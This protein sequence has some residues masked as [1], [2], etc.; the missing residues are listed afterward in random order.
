MYFH[1]IWYRIFPFDIVVRHHTCNFLQITTFNSVNAFTWTINDNRIWWP[2]KCSQMPRLIIPNMVR[3]FLSCGDLLG[4]AHIIY[5]PEFELD[6]WWWMELRMPSGIENETTQIFGTL[7]GASI[8]T[9]PATL[10]NAIS[11]AGLQ[12][13][14][15]SNQGHQQHTYMDLLYITDCG[16]LGNCL[17][18]HE[19]H[20]VHAV[21]AQVLSSSIPIPFV[22]PISLSLFICNRDWCNR[23]HSVQLISQFILT[24][25]SLNSFWDWCNRIQ[26]AE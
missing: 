8:F 15:V 26:F 16:F 21:C 14:S 4:N 22:Q 17:G 20:S 25:Q 5:L 19:T 6:F 23:V 7:P 3:Y 9:M 12:N 13:L 11:H 24:S 10:D 18:V 2:F 1:S